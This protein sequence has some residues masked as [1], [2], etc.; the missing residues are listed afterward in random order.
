M[1]K[2]NLLAFATAILCIANSCQKSN[3]SNTST[4]NDDYII[5]NNIKHSI[6]YAICTKTDSSFYIELDSVS[7]DGIN[8]PIFFTF[9]N[10]G[11]I[12]VGTFPAA[13]QYPNGNLFFNM[14]IADSLLANPASGYN[15][16]EFGI[17][18]NGSLTISNISNGA[19]SGSFLTE[20]QY[21]SITSKTRNTH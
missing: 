14:Q 12:N 16:V 17:I 2:I 19:A 8:Q 13:G 15:I 6:N 7:A 10:A 21:I 11:S 18:G 20:Q 4:K 3:S 5:I 9:S 1:K